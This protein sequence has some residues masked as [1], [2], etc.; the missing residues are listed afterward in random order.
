MNPDIFHDNTE[1]YIRERYQEFKT[2]I[3]DDIPIDISLGGEYM[4]VEGFEKRDP[5]E[6]LQF[7]TGKVL[8]E[9]SYY[10]ISHN[11][12]DAI[13]N[14][15]LAGLQPVIAHPERYLYLADHLNIFDRFFDM[16]ATFQLNLL[17]IGGAYGRTSIYIMNYL[18]KKGYYT[19]RGSDT[20]SIGH[21]DNI[22]SL[23]YPKAL[24]DIG[25]ASISNR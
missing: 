3:P 13:F 15:T 11:M 5:S 2:S 21:Y 24:L 20:H 18:L 14:L 10:F 22:T 4:V 7:Q 1:D 17:S 25:L 16:G 19:H 23:Q 9:M 6:L 12:E 8:I